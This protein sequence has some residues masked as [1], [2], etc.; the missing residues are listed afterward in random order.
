M[1]GNRCRHGTCLIKARGSLWGCCPFNLCP[2][3]LSGPIHAVL[4]TAYLCAG[5][6]LKL[7]LST[8]GIRS[9]LQSWRTAMVFHSSVW[10][11]RC[12]PQQFVTILHGWAHVVP[13]KSCLEWW[14]R[15]SDRNLSWEILILT[16]LLTSLAL[17]SLVFIVHVS[18]ASSY[19]CGTYFRTIC[20]QTIYRKCLCFLLSKNQCLRFWINNRMGKCYCCSHFSSTQMGESERKR[21]SWRS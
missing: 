10:E 4:G 20:H 14:L 1:T 7:H 6:K 5:P 15:S 12:K 21:W 19:P 11:Q 9:F 13:G 17:L 2:E 8:N 16:L 18:F 3:V